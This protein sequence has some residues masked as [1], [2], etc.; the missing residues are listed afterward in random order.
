M[1]LDHTRPIAPPFLQYQNPTACIQRWHHW[2]PSHRDRQY[3]RSLT[4]ILP[5]SPLKV[6]GHLAGE[7]LV[8]ETKIEIQGTRKKL[9]GIT[10]KLFSHPNPA[11]AAYTWTTLLS[12]MNCTTI[13]VET[14]KGRGEI[15]A[16]PL[17]LVS[18]N[19]IDSLFVLPLHKRWNSYDW[20]G[21]GKFL[22]NDYKCN[23]HWLE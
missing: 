1:C 15:S 18:R 11:L 8:P 7:H 9:M 3:P 6:A 22:K 19:P 23:S 12:S 2:Y 10:D 21:K 13:S 4:W 5:L 17:K 20:D 14:G 16:L